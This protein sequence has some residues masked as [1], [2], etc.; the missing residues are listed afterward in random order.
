LK[1][2]ARLILTNNST[3]NLPFKSTK[4]LTNNSANY[5]SR[6]SGLLI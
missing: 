4:N 3:K 6:S 2:I 5:R 1:S